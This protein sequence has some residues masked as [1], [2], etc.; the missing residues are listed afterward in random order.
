[1]NSKEPPP[2][3]MKTTIRYNSSTR[4]NNNSNN[5]QSQG[6]SS[7]KFWN[8]PLNELHFGESQQ[9]QQQQDQEEE[10]DI[11]SRSNGIQYSVDGETPAGSAIN[12]ARRTNNNNR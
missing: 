1:M 10:E 3:Q 5:N 4:N 8:N 11:W 12:A 7:R 6:K 9:Q 2:T